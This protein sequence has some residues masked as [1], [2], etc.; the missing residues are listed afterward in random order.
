MLFVLSVEKDSC[1]AMAFVYKVIYSVRAV[2]KNIQISITF[3][4]GKIAFFNKM[5]CEIS[6]LVS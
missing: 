2:L 1:L 5:R 4:R 6:P 3:G